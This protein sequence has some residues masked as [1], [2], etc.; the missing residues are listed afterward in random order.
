MSRINEGTRHVDDLHVG[1]L[2]KWDLCKSKRLRAVGEENVNSMS[3][4]ISFWGA[5]V[6]CKLVCYK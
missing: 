2:Y 1:K 6:I 5:A 3:S 4:W